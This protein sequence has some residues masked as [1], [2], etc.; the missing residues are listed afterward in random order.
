MELAKALRLATTAFLIS[1]GLGSS[2]T[3]TDRM[4]NTIL[5]RHHEQL[6]KNYQPVTL[7]AFRLLYR[8]T[9]TIESLPEPRAPTTAAAAPIANTHPEDSLAYNYDLLGTGTRFTLAQPPTAPRPQQ[10]DKMDREVMKILRTFDSIFV[11]PWN[12]YT[13]TM[14][15]N[16]IGLELK[17]LST[18]HFTENA[19]NDAAMEIDGEASADPVLG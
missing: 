17:K 9:H 18:S 6:L 12:L 3:D 7:E 1:D 13:D 5:D 4:V 2:L 19:T 16:D 14:T 8:E 10:I 11:V 15:K